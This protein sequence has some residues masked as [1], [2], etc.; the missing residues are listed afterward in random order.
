[1]E[2]IIN[3]QKQNSIS[4]LLFSTKDGKIIEHSSINSIFKR[5]CKCAGITKECNIHMTKHTGV[6]RMKENNIDIYVISKLV[7]TSVKVLTQTYAHI[8]DDFVEKEIEKSKI[9]RQENNLKLS[10]NNED[11]NCKIIPFKKYV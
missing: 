11:S 4:N 3:E 9:V 6:T 7:G 5:I 1:M 10:Y 2:F 8:F